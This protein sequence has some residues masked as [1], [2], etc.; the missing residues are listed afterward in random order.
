MFVTWPKVRL[1]LIAG[2]DFIHIGC[3]PPPKLRIW[4]RRTHHAH[5]AQ[6]GSITNMKVVVCILLFKDTCYTGFHF[7]HG[8]CVVLAQNN[9]ETPEKLQSPHL[10]DNH[11]VLLYVK[12][13]AVSLKVANSIVHMITYR[14]NPQKPQKWHFL[15]ISGPSI[16]GIPIRYLGGFNNTSIQIVQSSKTPRTHVDVDWGKETT[17]K[18]VI[19]YNV[20]LDG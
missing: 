10:N 5:H 1:W 4:C 9:R 17:Q 8:S 11:T 7:W 15:L 19:N 18:I 16:S 14:Q 6:V 3:N 2:M 12:N 20:Y 13:K